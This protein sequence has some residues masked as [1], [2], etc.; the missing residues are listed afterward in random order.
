MATLNYAQ[1]QLLPWVI[2]AAP[3]TSVLK[4]VCKTW[5]GTRV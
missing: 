2:T 3:R 5:A 1:R 4:L